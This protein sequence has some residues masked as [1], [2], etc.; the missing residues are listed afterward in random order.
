MK[1]VFRF[2]LGFIFIVF[3]LTFI[4]DIIFTIF[5]LPIAIL[6][7]KRLSDAGVKPRY[8]NCLNQCLNY[9]GYWK[10]WQ[11]DYFKEKDRVK[12]EIKN[13]FKN[14]FLKLSQICKGGVIKIGTNEWVY[15]NVIKDLGREYEVLIDDKSIEFKPQYLEKLD[16]MSSITVWK[17]IFSSKFWKV[18]FRDE[19]IYTYYV[20]V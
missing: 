9:R 6:L 20:K 2:I 19:V 5:K 8:K 11:I 17:N 15:N 7:Y 3:K 10:Y 4:V 13:D 1:K 12:K 14:D 18:L 16:L